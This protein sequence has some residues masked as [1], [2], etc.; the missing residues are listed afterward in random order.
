MAQRASLPESST[1]ITPGFSWELILDFKFD[2]V[3]PSDWG[4]WGVRVMVWSDLVGVKLV[5]G[6]GVAFEAV[7]GL[8]GAGGPHL[9]P[10]ARMTGA[11]TELFR[12]APTINYLISLHAPGGIEEPYLGGSMRLAPTPPRE[13]LAL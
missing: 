11:Q 1:T 8:V 12:N 5:P 10:V 2:E 3:R 6:N 13:L 9:V 4:S 7:D